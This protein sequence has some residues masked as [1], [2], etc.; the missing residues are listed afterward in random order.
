MSVGQTEGWTDR[1]LEMTRC[2][3]HVKLFLVLQVVKERDIIG[4]QLI[5]RNDEVLLLYQKIKIIEMTLY[6]GELQYNERLEDIRIL[7]LEISSLRCK[8]SVLEK[9]NR[10]VDDLRFG[11]LVCGEIALRIALRMSVCPS[12]CPPRSLT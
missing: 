5:R 2:Q 8:N 4:A 3:Q 10:A 9:D 11:K 1:Q 12:V 6:K 7:K